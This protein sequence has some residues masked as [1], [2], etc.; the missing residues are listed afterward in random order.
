M[1]QLYPELVSTQGLAELADI[2][3]CQEVRMFDINGRTVAASGGKDAYTLSRDPA[4]R[5]YLFRS[6]LTGTEYLCQKPLKSD[7]GEMVQ[8]AGA[9][10]HDE[11][12]DIKGCVQIAVEPLQLM[13]ATSSYSFESVLSS[14]VS[15]D[16][17]FCFAVNKEDN[18]IAWSPVQHLA[19][20]DVLEY[21]LKQTQLRDKFSGFID[22]NGE[23]CFASCSE[24]DEHFV[25]VAVPETSV[26]YQ[27]ASLT[28]L[29]GLVTAAAILFLI[30]LLP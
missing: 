10:V 6:L 11:N 24:T 16:G 7:S 1:I 23:R 27:R 25:F 20:K 26:Y 15:A 2:L 18:T 4:S 3:D 28:V 30:L 14:Y 29:Y 17:S 13:S 19:G 21:G 8:Y 22:F 12:Y 9:A 5:D